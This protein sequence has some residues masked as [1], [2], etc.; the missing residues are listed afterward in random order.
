MKPL[1]IS[2]WAASAPFSLVVDDERGWTF[3]SR[4]V[5]RLNHRCR[6]H[7]SK[8]RSTFR[9]RIWVYNFLYFCNRDLLNGM[10]GQA[11]NPWWPYRRI[12][13]PSN[14]Q[15]Q[16][17]PKRPLLKMSQKKS[18]RILIPMSQTPMNPFLQ[19]LVRAQVVQRVPMQLVTTVMTI[20]VPQPV[21]IP[22]RW[23]SWN[24]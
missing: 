12:G 13:Q 24:S 22:N 2:G 3:N 10:I 7:K 21:V 18:L 19:S 23:P 4:R 8:S 14:H 5:C 11:K 16:T 15:T 9:I 6:C 1:Q 17:F 20:L